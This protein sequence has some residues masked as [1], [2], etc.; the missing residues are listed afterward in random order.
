MWERVLPTFVANYR[1][2]VIDT[3]RAYKSMAERALD[4][5]SDEEFFLRI[6]PTSN[7]IAIIVKHISGNQISRFTDFLTA[8]GEKPERNR[9][10]EFINDGDTR[11]RLMERWDTG[12]RTL[13][14][15]IE[16]LKPGDFDKSVK[17]RGEVHTVPEAINRQLTH[18]AYHIGQLV[19]LAKHYKMAD[20]ETLSVPLNRSAEFN[21]FLAAKKASGE[22]P[23][24][25]LEGP[26]E[27]ALQDKR[28]VK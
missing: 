11:P 10:S 14:F 28:K 7:S 15:A 5:L 13:F 27:F 26:A 24:H 18:Y 25:P 23:T 17:I 21:D 8:D 1:N 12:W 22:T 16:H 4:Q 19:L 2:N 20:W 9:D 6:D 3:F